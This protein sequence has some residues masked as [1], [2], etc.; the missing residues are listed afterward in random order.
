MSLTKIRN[1]SVTFILDTRG[2]EESVETV[3]EHLGSVLKSLGASVSRIES[4]GRHDFARVTDR[5]H[6]GDT[7]VTGEF[8]AA[9]DVPARLHERLRL[10]KKVKRL[11]VQS[12]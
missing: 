6:T 5:N 2:L 9:A 1:Y 10:D 8:S 11:V 3:V 12:A 4:I 7:F